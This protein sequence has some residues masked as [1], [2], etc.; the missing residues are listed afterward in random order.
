MKHA[1][2]LALLLTAGTPALP[3][4]IH[5][6]AQK[7]DQC[8]GTLKERQDDLFLGDDK[9]ESICVI[10]K[11][12]EKKV[13][14][15]RHIGAFCRLVGITSLCRD[16]GECV[17]ITNIQTMTTGA[18]ATP[19]PKKVTCSGDFMD[20]N[21]PYLATAPLSPPGLCYES[22]TFTHQVLEKIL[23]TCNDGY[24]C[25]IK[26]HITQTSGHYYWDRI[27]SVTLGEESVPHSAGCASV[28]WAWW[29][30]K[31]PGKE[32]DC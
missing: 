8:T 3:A 11:S 24:E 31:H 5:A 16:S 25:T 20:L 30:R 6:Q 26:G 15:K 22:I 10:H 21:G 29:R 18:A 19:L 28:Y 4:P 23:K 13:L 12:Q 32:P 17:E 14:A 2:I 7:L 9:D 1:V 27:L